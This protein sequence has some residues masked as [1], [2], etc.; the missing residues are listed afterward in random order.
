[1]E[2]GGRDGGVALIGRG[3][4]EGDCSCSPDCLVLEEKGG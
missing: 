2:G 3:G 4:E 1:M